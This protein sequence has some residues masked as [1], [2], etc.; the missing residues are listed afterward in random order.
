MDVRCRL[1]G[2]GRKIGA[3]SA[4]AVG[5]GAPEIEDALIGIGEGHHMA[6]GHA[7]ENLTV[8]GVDW[9]TV[10]PGSRYRIGDG[11]EIEITSYT[12][13]C[14]T[15]ARW[16]SDGDFTRM[17]QTRFPGE[18]RVYARVLTEGTVRPGDAFTPL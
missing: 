5:I 10:V 3:E 9:A 8:A 1:A 2:D 6:P 12:K 7:G 13:P 14:A 18:S 15:N 11:V 16:F 17:L 4:H